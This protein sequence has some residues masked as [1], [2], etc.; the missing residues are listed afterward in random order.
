M[1]AWQ[2]RAA[3]TSLLWTGSSF[4]PCLSIPLTDRGFRYGMAFFES[5]A[6]REGRAEF[7]EAHLARLDAAC[8]QC[9]WPVE[10]AAL[11]RA[12]EQLE[13]LAQSSSAQLFS[14][15]YLTAGDGGP[16]DPVT[17]PRLFV[18]AEPRPLPAAHSLRVRLHPA[19]F[20]PVLDGLKTAN[21]WPNAEALRQARQ[22]G[23]DE[24]LL[25]NPSGD[26]VSTCM[27][28]VFIEVAGEWITPPPSCGARQGVTREWVMRR[29]EISE[30]PV[31]RDD[32]SRATACFLTSCWSGPVPV[33]HLEERALDPGFAMALSAEFFGEP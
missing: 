10:S 13:R 19:P 15:I 4:E 18:F 21:Y 20:L 6:V 24:A 25:F 27:A 17:A 32:L 33:S 23:A 5:I 28:N 11:Q 26:L 30:R 22:S 3:S 2:Q 1:E 14:R 29:R 7:L 12:G 16:A 31:R 9:G 8:R